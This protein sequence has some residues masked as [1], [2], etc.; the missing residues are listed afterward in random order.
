M[1]VR[2]DKTDITKMYAN[3]RAKLEHIIKNHI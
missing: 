2:Y 1:A 3:K